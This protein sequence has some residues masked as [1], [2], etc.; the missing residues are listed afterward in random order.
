MYTLSYRKLTNL[1]IPVQYIKLYAV[2][3]PA[4]WHFIYQPSTAFA[5]FPFHLKLWDNQDFDKLLIPISYWLQYQ[6][7]LRRFQWYLEPDSISFFLRLLN[8]SGCLTMWFFSV[9][10]NFEAKLAA[11]IHGGGKSFGRKLYKLQQLKLL[12][13]HHRCYAN[14]VLIKK[15]KL[16]YGNTEFDL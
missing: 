14:D 12:R 1:R 6:T 15:A 11:K 8:V 13:H 4:F 5:S 3:L 2:P 10:F 7:T 9:S 16:K